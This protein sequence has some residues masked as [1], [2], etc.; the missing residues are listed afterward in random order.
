MAKIATRY[1]PTSLG[2]QVPHYWNPIRAGIGPYDFPAQDRGQL[3]WPRDTLPCSV[4]AVLTQYLRAR[5]HCGARDN[6][7]H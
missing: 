5:S 7:E 6:R 2:V 4:A 3:R 1:I